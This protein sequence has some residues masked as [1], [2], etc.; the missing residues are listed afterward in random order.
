ML[1]ELTGIKIAQVVI[2][3]SSEDLTTN[4]FISQRKD[5]PVYIKKMKEFISTFN[6]QNHDNIKEVLN[7]SIK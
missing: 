6:K 4:E 1:E 5:M 3:V 7:G 2:L